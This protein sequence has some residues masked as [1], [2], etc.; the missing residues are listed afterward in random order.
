MSRVK[1]PDLEDFLKVEEFRENGTFVIRAELPGID[2]EKDV[3][4]TITD[5][6]LRISAERRQEIKTE[7]KDRYHSEFHYGSFSRV[8]RLVPGTKQ[9]DVTATYKDGILEIRLPV[10]TEQ[11]SV[12]KI[13]I[14]KS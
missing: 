6:T 4:I 1:L 2:P 12:K 8:L 13:A 9:D 11:T 5:D 3:D 10:D 7:D 14:T